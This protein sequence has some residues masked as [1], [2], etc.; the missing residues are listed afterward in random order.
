MA[1]EEKQQDK[2]VE[3]A[4]ESANHETPKESKSE[5]SK[6]NHG[7]PWHCALNH[8]KISLPLAVLVIVGLILAAP[9]TRYAV[10]SLV[11]KQSLPVIVLDEQTKAPVS[12][13]Q[14]LIK[15]VVATTDSKG[16][17]TVKVPVG[18]TELKASKQYY[19]SNAKTLT[20]PIGKPKSPVHITLHATG[21]QVPISVLNSVGGGPVSNA[22]LSALNT[23][24]RTDE[25]GKA[26]LVVPADAT[27]LAAT[28]KASGYNDASV[29]IKVTTATDPANNFKVTPVGKLYFLSDR[30][31]KLD[32]V[33]SNLDGSERKVV[34]PGTGKEIK[35]STVLLASRDWKYIALL[36]QR[37]GGENPKLFLIETDTDKLTTMDEGKA[38]FTP[39][40]WS[41]DRFV[42][43][44]SRTNVEYYQ[45]KKYAL[46]SYQASTKKIVL[47]DESAGGG[48]PAQYQT[49]RLADAYIFDKEVVYTKQWDSLYIYGLPASLNTIQADGSQKKKV[50]TYTP[51][52]PNGFTYLNTKPGEFNE[53]YIQC[54]GCAPDKST[55]DEYADGKITAAASSY[56][57]AQFAND[58]YNRYIVS[59]SGKKTLWTETRDGRNVFFVGDSKGEHGKQL[60]E[61]SDEFVAYGWYSDDYLLVTRKSSEML[62][63]PADG[64]KGGIESA[65]KVSDYYKP[66]YL[67]RGYGY[68]YGG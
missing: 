22:V 5:P 49:E 56:G 61:A 58:V 64:L 1:T 8:K 40:G 14:V 10:L 68:G 6:A 51:A 47:L 3:E 28:L 66:N 2:K 59:P 54:L 11:I 44:V 34:L 30:S 4:D 13:A 35:Q 33:K 38:Q 46:K 63:V 60:G 18:P 17:A 19:K 29:T 50:K 67:I 52:A 65:A 16:R 48:S 21:R 39:Y 37:D 32:V 12:S 57:D 15:G 42:Y 25:K 55:F 62:I 27:Q 41:G 43:L 53:L 36:S 45:P 9:V 26:T 24:V 31:G 20:V 23:K 7:T